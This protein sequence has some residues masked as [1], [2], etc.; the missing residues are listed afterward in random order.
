[1]NYEPIAAVSLPKTPSSGSLS[2]WA[3]WA[4]E[5]AGTVT[6]W[7]LNWLNR[8]AMLAVTVAGLFVVAEVFRVRLTLGG[9]KK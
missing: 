8:N 9:G 4:L 5:A 6:M 1:M 3:T 7:A 2:A